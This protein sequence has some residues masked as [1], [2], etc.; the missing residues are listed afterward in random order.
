MGGL[1]PLHCPGPSPLIWFLISRHL[2]EATAKCSGCW[3]PWF[4]SMYCGTMI[5]L[6]H[7]YCSIDFRFQSERPRAASPEAQKSFRCSFKFIR[8]HLSS[9]TPGKWFKC[10][11]IPR[12][13]RF[14]TSVASDLKR[15]WRQVFAFSKKV[16]RLLV[17][18]FT[19]HWAGCLINL[20]SNFEGML[21]T[22]RRG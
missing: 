18:L 3:C 19:W 13:S 6:T 20:W 11:F 9:G 21:W 22:V 14:N 1:V 7:L 15:L 12:I 5:L 2:V 16:Q 4:P 10:V 8:N 17:Y